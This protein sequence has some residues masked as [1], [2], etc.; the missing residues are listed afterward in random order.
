M[1]F[2]SYKHKLTPHKSSASAHKSWDVSN[3]LLSYNTGFDVE[4]GVTSPGK[5]GLDL[6]DSFFE[7]SKTADLWQGSCFELFIKI[8]EKYWEWNFT[9]SGRSHH[10]FFEGWRNRISSS[11]GGAVITGDGGI[12]K[13]SIDASAYPLLQWYLLNRPKETVVE[14]QCSCILKVGG[15]KSYWSSRINPS[16]DPNF[17][18]PDSFLVL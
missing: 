13:A 2:I 1:T 4:F 8:D 15:E 9:P 7:Y 12:V 3:L 17:H 14:Y 10:Y 16:E 11:V 6:K 5:E 18:S